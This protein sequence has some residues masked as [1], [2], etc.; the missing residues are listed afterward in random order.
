MV[1]S[2]LVSA[3]SRKASLC[4]AH[5]HSASSLRRV[6]PRYF[7]RPS[8][9]LLALCSVCSDLKRTGF[10]LN[11]FGF[12]HLGGIDRGSIT[13]SKNCKHHEDRVDPASCV[14][15]V[16]LPH[17]HR[18]DKQTFPQQTD[19]AGVR[20][21]LVEVGNQARGGRSKKT[22]RVSG[23]VECQSTERLKG[24]AGMNGVSMVGQIK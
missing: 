17:S 21:N 2:P 12:R 7:V 6:Q 11:V 16:S 14:R 23:A 19:C 18:V 13:A 9:R 3:A 15:M 4:V 10:C 8:P 22:Q 1:A 5:G 24:A 20:T